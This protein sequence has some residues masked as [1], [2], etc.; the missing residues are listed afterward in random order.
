MM[1]DQQQDELSDT[2]Q[3][4]LTPLRESD[5]DGGTDNERDQHIENGKGP[6]AEGGADSIEQHYTDELASVSGEES[7]TQQPNKDGLTRE[8][9]ISVGPGPRYP[10]EALVACDLCQTVGFESIAALQAHLESAHGKA[11]HSYVAAQRLHTCA[12][13]SEPLTT[14]HRALCDSCREKHEAGHQRPVQ[15]PC[16][17][18]GEKY[19][20]RSDPFCS[21]ACAANR[22][23][24]GPPFEPPADIDASWSASSL[25]VE[26]GIPNAAPRLANNRFTCR[27][28]YQHGS[29]SLW[30]IL[31]HASRSHKGGR[32]YIAEVQLRRCRTCDG[33]MRRLDS[34]YCSEECRHDDSEP[35]EKCPRC[36]ETPLDIGESICSR[37]CE[38]GFD[39]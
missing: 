19:V 32:A 37:G 27:I 17:W 20:T 11:L 34:R 26:A 9:V 14:L 18:C 8:Q 31:T 13:C 1:P 33:P 38:S 36:G 28:C 16:Q 21:P 10:S 30:G 4:H 25:R 5:S 23:Q 29:D 3:R 6:P 7:T 35:V 22:L 24:Y 15:V 2:L 39:S 12:A